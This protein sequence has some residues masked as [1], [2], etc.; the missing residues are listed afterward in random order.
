MAVGIVGLVPGANAMPPSP[1]SMLFL[2][3]RTVLAGSVFKGHVHFAMAQDVF[4]D[5]TPD[6]QWQALQELRR[7]SAWFL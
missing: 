4:V 2:L 5:G 1:F 6:F 7:L 3:A